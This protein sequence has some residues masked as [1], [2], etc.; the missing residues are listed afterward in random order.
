MP[1]FPRRMEKTL[2]H[3]LSLANERR[4]KYST[5]EHLLLALVDD[6]DASATLVACG[7]DVP[8]LKSALI[9][10]I[11]T[12]LEELISDDAEEAKATEA[13]QRV[14]Q[15][16]AFQVQ[17]AGRD[18]VTGA[19]VL[20]ALFPERETHATYFLEQQDITRYDVVNYVS[21]GITKKST[22]TSFQAVKISN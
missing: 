21:H 12:E 19:N 9:T 8:A 6:E 1:L 18:E 15:R 22:S 14:V 2:R 10:Y 20:V 17:S 13:F 3:A 7:G 16:A 11:D 5:L 4:H